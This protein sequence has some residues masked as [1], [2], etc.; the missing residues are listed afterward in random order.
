[1]A[2]RPSPTPN[3]L[4]IGP[5]KAGTTWLHEVLL[6][7]PSVYLTPA[8]DLYYFSRYYDRGDSWYFQKFR[9]APSTASIIG[10]I[11]PDYLMSIDAPKRVESSLGQDVRLMVTLRD[12][13]ERAF[14]A[15]LYL[16]RQGIASGTFRQCA[17]EHQDVLDE[18]RYSTHLRRYLTYFS[19]ES[20]RIG[21][22]DDL[23][24]DPQRFLDETTDFLAIERLPLREV[25]REPVL[26]AS[27]ARSRHVSLLVRNG[28]TWV[29]R[30]NGDRLVGAVKRNKSVQSLLYTSYE[31]ERPIMSPEDRAFVMDT[32]CGEL[33]FVER[34]FGI[35]LSDRWGWR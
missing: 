12:P 11:C 15:Y 28:A 3:F 33:N 14:S 16:K 17:L 22:F 18:G 26:R 2:S 29:R 7:H 25:Q 9:Q 21:V 32:L 8:K 13:V 23:E 19:S 4:H 10:E 34:E 20:L 30:H 6:N 27:S 1:M 5:S 31:D 35:P 24:D